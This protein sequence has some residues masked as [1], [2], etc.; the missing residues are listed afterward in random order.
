MKATEQKEKNI[1]TLS[2]LLLS[3]LKPFSKHPFKPHNEEKMLELAE[4]IK[5]QGLI[6]PILVRPIVDE[7]YSHEIV[8]GHNRVKAA[9]LTEIK[10]I[11]CDVRELDDAQ[12]V[13]IMVDSNLQRE[14]IL[15]S[16]K[17][18]AYK[19][20]LDAIKSQGK[21][22]DIT[23]CQLGTKL[24]S[25][26]QI[27]IEHDDSRRDI[28]RYVSLTNLLPSLLDKVDERRLA[29][30]P[31]VEL[32]YLNKDE[33]EWLHTILNREE[34]FGVPLAIATK[35][36]GISKNGTLTFE[37]ID[38][39]IVT[40]NQEPPKA[41]KISY[42]T[43]KAFFPKGTTPQEYEKVIKQALEEWFENHSIPKEK[44]KSKSIER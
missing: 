28:Y 18:F 24:N 37:K 38:N 10:K 23:L 30:I 41:V 35:L 36:K 17:A 43:V 7:K 22:T 33:Q 31:A 32:S 21:R 4:S 5:E 29:F 26:N 12:A 19:Y 15:P 8:A 27:A 39:I 40:K 20:K 1:E 11:P 2:S 34:H 13:I 25:G 3:K 42:R 14:T 6:V 44:N 16:E 9:Q